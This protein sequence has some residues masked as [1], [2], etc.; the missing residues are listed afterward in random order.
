MPNLRDKFVKEFEDM[1]KSFKDK[2]FTDPNFPPE[3]SSIIKPQ[4]ESRVPELQVP[5]DI[6]FCRAPYLPE[7]ASITGEI[8]LFKD[9]IEP[10]D[11]LQGGLGN[12][13][14]LCSLAALAEKPERIEKLYL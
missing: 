5:H 12:G 7:I 13:Y 4:N 9:G 6:K 8:E 10:A 2:K 3:R 11:I 1:V 14:L